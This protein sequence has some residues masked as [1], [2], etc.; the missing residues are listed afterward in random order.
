MVEQLPGSAGSGLSGL[1]ILLIGLVG[2]GCTYTTDGMSPGS[3][4][5]RQP[6]TLPSL[7]TSPPS[8]ASPTPPPDGTFAGAAQLSSSPGSL[9]RR[10]I[11]IR[12]FMVTGNRVRF[13]GFRGTIQPDM[14]VEMQA[15]GSFLYGSFD[16][17]RFIGSF[18]R[19]HPACSYILL[20]D[21]VG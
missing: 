3:V 7:A 9:C 4:T 2:S 19:P 8:Q 15:G 16:G 14:S 5:F 20:L 12:N 13:Q 1:L 10:E 17:G 18:W 6:G 21:H 11:P